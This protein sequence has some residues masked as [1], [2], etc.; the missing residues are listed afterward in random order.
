MVIFV[1]IAL[2]LSHGLLAATPQSQSSQQQP[3]TLRLDP[4]TGLT[5]V[6]E[7]QLD[8]TLRFDPESGLPLQESSVQPPLPRTSPEPG[9]GESAKQLVDGKFKPFQFFARQ[10]FPIQFIGGQQI[11]GRGAGGN[12]ALSYRFSE[13]VE[14][15]GYR[16]IY[17]S[18]YVYP[19]L[20]LGVLTVNR[21]YLRPEQRNE[22]TIY[23]M[24]EGHRRW[25]MEIIR[26]A[27]FIGVGLGGYEVG[28]QELREV[29]DP[30]GSRLESGSG[31]KKERGYGLILST[32]AK[33]SS[34]A[35]MAGLHLYRSPGLGEIV[36]VANVG[37]Q[38]HDYKAVMIIGAGSLA[39]LVLRVLL[40]PGN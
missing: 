29:M 22:Y 12:L 30:G 18:F 27:L 4:E 21:E 10:P 16:D 14:I 11:Y 40:I 19:E 13:E 38:P 28:R 20:T 26:A 35:L 17:E 32:G 33:V 3:D 34:R 5:V 8:T 15:K 1:V 39:L 2:I 7:T 6:K 23:G 36:T 31:F 37:Y 9:A 24:I 25:E